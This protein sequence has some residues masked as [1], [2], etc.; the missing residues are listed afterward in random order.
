M[1]EPSF[2][3]KYEG[4]VAKFSNSG[5][6][7]V[8]P[9]MGAKRTVV[10]APDDHDIEEGD[11]ITFKINR[12]RD[13]YYQAKLI[14]HRSVTAGYNTPPNIPIHHDG[15]STGSTRS[16]REATKS[17]DKRGFDPETKKE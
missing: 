1:G 8:K 6:P 15:Q 13:S 9:G 12:E 4:S 16:E 5:N 3:K 14:N 17:V 2:G 11:R 10:H 7:I